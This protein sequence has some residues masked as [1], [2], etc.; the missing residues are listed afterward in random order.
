MVPKFNA[1][2]QANA[3]K[4]YNDYTAADKAIVDEILKIAISF[5]RRLVAFKVRATRACFVTKS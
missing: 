1:V 2:L 3:S 4:A 5:N